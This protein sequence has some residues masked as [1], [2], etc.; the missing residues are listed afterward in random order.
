M[1]HFT[2]AHNLNGTT[3]FRKAYNL[4]RIIIHEM[5]DPVTQ[6]ADNDIA[7]LQLDGSIVPSDEVNVVCLPEEGSRVP[8]GKQCWGT[9]N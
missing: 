9:G 1:I 4:N 2:G 7:L 6:K 5:F 8:A 3:A